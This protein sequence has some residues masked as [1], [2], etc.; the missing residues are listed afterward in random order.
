MNA[1]VTEKVG[2]QCT[3]S[4]IDGGCPDEDECRLTCAPCY[5]GIGK[6]ESFCD[7]HFELPFYL[8][9]CVMSE[10]APCHPIGPPQCPNNNNPPS[11]TSL[12]G[13]SQ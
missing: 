3:L 12:L 11:P 4:V 2:A 10:G 5:V 1:E 8:C 13:R 9:T 7:V 6:V